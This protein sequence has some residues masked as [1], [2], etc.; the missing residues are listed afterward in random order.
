[1]ITR[2]HDGALVM[3][4]TFEA[5]PMLLRDAAGAPTD[6]AQLAAMLA[7]ARAGQIDGPIEFDARVYRQTLGAPLTPGRR[8]MKQNIL[9]RPGAMRAL[10]RSFRGRPFLGGHDWSSPMARGGTIGDSWLDEALPLGAAAD[11]SAT[12]TILETIQ[13][14]EP[15]SVAGVLGGAISEFSIGMVPTGDIMCSIHDTPVWDAC[16]CCPGDMI[17]AAPGPGQPDT[18]TMAQWIVSAAE[19][20]E[21]SAVNVPAVGAG[22]TGIEAIRA[23]LASIGLTLDAFTG[24]IWTDSR[25]GRIDLERLDDAADLAALAAAQGLSPSRISEALA[26]R[27][28]GLYDGTQPAA[29]GHRRS[30]PMNRYLKLATVLGMSL[31]A[32]APLDEER[33]IA[34]VEGVKAERDLFRARAEAAEKTIADQAKAEAAKEVDAI[35]AAA[36]V[37]G[38]L[39]ATVAADGVTRMPDPQESSLRKIAAGLG[40]DALKAHVLAMPAIRPRRA[41]SIVEV[42]PPVRAEGGGLTPAMK[43][44]AKQCG[45]PETDMLATATATGR[46]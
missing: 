7:R 22:A 30:T 18:R 16:Y 9:I 39:A 15:W 43:L 2:R 44:A 34:T 10:T 8:S 12:Q 19:G 38:K 46:L 45:I 35:I 33:A 1:M 11:S 21:T 41:V 17:G 27:R 28:H 26:A 5:R 31:A 14:S 42:V 23:G 40:L 37:D 25:T 3:G 13:A 4:A 24:S 36:E 6:A 20:V 32:D 29:S